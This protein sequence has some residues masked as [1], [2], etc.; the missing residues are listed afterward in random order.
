MLSKG[1]FQLAKSA[2]MNSNHRYKVGCVIA[3][4]GKPVTVGFNV[5][6]S[7]PQ[8][9]TCEHPSIHAE[10]KAIINA[11]CNLQ[12]GIAYVYRETRNGQ[13]ALAKPCNLCY[14]ILQ[15]AGIK[16]VYYSTN[17][18]PYWSVEKL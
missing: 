16:S 15:E 7:H 6:K 5:C 3:L 8:Y 11:R 12:G 13:S 17:Q 10:V 1:F 9:T 14:N 2:S 4:H 18:Y